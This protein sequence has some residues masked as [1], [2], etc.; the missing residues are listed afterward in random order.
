MRNLGFLIPGLFYAVSLQAQIIDP[1]QT[2]KRKATDRANSRIDQ[3]MDRGL[4]K[5]EEGIGSI[6]R[7]KEKRSGSSEADTDTKKS[8]NDQEKGSNDRN[9]GAS[10]LTD[11]VATDFQ[12]YKKSDFQPGKDVIFFEDFTAGSGQWGLNEWD[13]DEGTAPGIVSIDRRN[14]KWYKMP[15]KGN[16]VPIP[17]ESLPE[18]FTLEYDMY[19]DLDRMSE[20]EGGLKVILASA[21]VNRLDFS[22]HFDD[23]PQIQLDVHPSVDLMYVSATREYGLDERNLFRKEYKDAWPKGAIRHI[24]VSRNK[25]HIK[26]YIDEKKYLDLPDALPRGGRYSLLF[27]TNLWGDGLYFTNIRL[28]SGGTDATGEIKGTG[29]FSTGNIYFDLNSARIKPESWPALKEAAAAVGAAGTDV[30]IVGHTDSDGPSDANLALSRRRAESVKIALV[31]E[32]GIREQKL[33]I[34]GKGEKVPLE[35]NSTASGKAKN[36]RVEFIKQ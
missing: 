23:K 18:T 6:F 20:M 35:S 7:K 24:S 26:L 16:F 4:D 9:S 5:V 11:S 1:N 13:R 14:E 34:D 8:S 29:R 22:F 10:L 25:S 30:L 3:G 32:F 15:R 2:V 33:F 36:R 31:K 27:A 19:A 12:P 21:G 28:A 17:V